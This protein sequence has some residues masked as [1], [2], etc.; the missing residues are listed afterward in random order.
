MNALLS[1]LAVLVLVGGGVVLLRYWSLQKVRALQ[2]Q[3]LP[4][5]W[6]RRLPDR[7]LLFLTTPQCSVCR[8]QRPMV[9]EL[10]KHIPVREVNLQ[11]APD[12]VQHLQIFG[13]PTYLWVERGTIR[14]SWVGAQSMQRFRFLWEQEGART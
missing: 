1:L 14:Y 10:R 5:S 6:H 8:A 7:V 3:R 9:Q 13:T 4:D 12:L 11:R 2:G